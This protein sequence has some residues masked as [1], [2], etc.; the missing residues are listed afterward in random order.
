MLFNSFFS[1]KSFYAWSSKESV[2]TFCIFYYIFCICRLCNRSTKGGDC[3]RTF[4]KPLAILSEVNDEIGSYRVYVQIKKKDGKYDEDEGINQ[5]EEIVNTKESI[6]GKENKFNN[7]YKVLVCTGEF[8]PRIKEL[9]QEKNI[10]LID[11]IQLI[12]MCLKNI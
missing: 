7:F 9:A 3:D 5:L 12:R 8:S 1:C 10:I 4:I 11:G 6:E 2:Y